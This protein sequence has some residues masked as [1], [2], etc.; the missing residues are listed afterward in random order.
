MEHQ[1]SNLAKHQTSNPVVRRLIDGY[2]NVLLD[3]VREQRPATVL[4]VGCGEGFAAEQLKKL[5]F[6]I[7]YLGVDLNASA[8]AYAREHVTGRRFEVADVRDLGARAAD[9][10]ICLEV[11]EHLDDPTQGIDALAGAAGKAVV[12][13]VPWEPWFRLGNLARGKYLGRLGNHPEHVQQ[14]GPRSIQAL[15]ATRFDD[16]QTRT[17]FPWVFAWGRCR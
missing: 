5:P 15:L 16:V 14:F 17:A 1:S 11:L 9:L 8:V 13:S 12:V 7:D 2:F 4:D 3:V 10:V 6:D